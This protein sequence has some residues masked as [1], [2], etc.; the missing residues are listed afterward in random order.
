MHRTALL[1]LALLALLLVASCS[2]DGVSDA[3]AVAAD[4][5][6]SPPVETDDTTDTT[7]LDGATEPSP[8]IVAGVFDLAADWSDFEDRPGVPPGGVFNNRIVIRRPSGERTLFLSESG[9]LADAPDAEAGSVVG[10]RPAPQTP[11][12]TEAYNG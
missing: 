5:Q 8:I 4:A 1:S 10:P 12:Y 11:E 3:G 7:D 2:S 6:T 9:A